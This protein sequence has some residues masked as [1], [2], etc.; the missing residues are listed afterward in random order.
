MNE[1]AIIYPPPIHCFYFFVEETIQGH[2]YTYLYMRDNKLIFDSITVSAL[3]ILPIFI[4]D[5]MPVNLR[6][7]SNQI[8]KEFIDKT[9]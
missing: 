9:R 6:N 2:K 8:I 7:H 5:R 1:L 4:M 3:E